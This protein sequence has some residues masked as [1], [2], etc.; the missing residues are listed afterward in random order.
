VRARRLHFQPAPNP[1]KV[2]RVG[3]RVAH[4]LAVYPTGFAHVMAQ[5]RGGSGTD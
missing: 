3:S 4:N 5:V 1:K 2:V